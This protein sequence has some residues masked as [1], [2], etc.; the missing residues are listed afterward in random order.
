LICWFEQWKR[1]KKNC[2]QLKVVLA[3]FLESLTKRL[4][5]CDDENIEILIQ[6]QSVVLKFYIDIILEAAPFFNLNS[7][8]GKK[9]RN[10]NKY[11]FPTAKW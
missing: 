4:D 11:K 8:K 5:S 9:S 2:I 10:L 7:L 6:T 3:F 1:R